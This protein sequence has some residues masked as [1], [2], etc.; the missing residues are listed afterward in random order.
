MHVTFIKVFQ[1]SYCS[2]YMHQFGQNII[3]HKRHA[4]NVPQVHNK[5]K[6][7]AHT[8]GTNPQTIISRITRLVLEF[9]V[10]YP[11]SRLSS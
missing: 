7:A 11:L 5:T 3:I 9:G 8:Y 1:F 2:T 10:E 4:Q 6:Q